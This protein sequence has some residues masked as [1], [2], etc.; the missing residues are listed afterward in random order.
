MSTSPAAWQGS[1][2]MCSAGRAESGTPEVMK[3]GCVTFQAAPRTGRGSFQVSGPT[4]TSLQPFVVEVE[5]DCGLP[6]YG[7]PVSFGLTSGSATL[8]PTYVYTGADGLAGFKVIAA[9][10][11]SLETGRVVE[12]T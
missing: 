7:Q 6:V 12:V 5:T 10:I 8:S 4:G 9:G 1:R 3:C 2:S 11:E